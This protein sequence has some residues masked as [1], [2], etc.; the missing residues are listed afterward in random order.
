MPVV[1]NE[2]VEKTNHLSRLISQQEEPLEKARQL[3][4]KRKILLYSNIALIFAVALSVGL[5]LG[6]RR[7]SDENDNNQIEGDIYDATTRNKIDLTFL[8]IIR[9]SRH[10]TIL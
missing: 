9:P 5:A 10:P 4:D 7:S 2:Q 8:I 6:L 3:N 1:K